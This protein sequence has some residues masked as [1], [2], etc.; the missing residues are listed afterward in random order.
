MTIIKRNGLGRPLTWTE[1]DSNF[2]SISEVDVK[3][4]QAQ[5]YAQSA[6]SSASSASGASSTAQNA[7]AQAV[8]AQ[9]EVINA[10]SDLTDEYADVSGSSKIG[11]KFKQLVS[12]KP[13]DVSDKLDS[14][15]ASVTDFNTFSS[16]LSSGESF[17]LLKKGTYSASSLVVPSGV[18]LMV[19]DGVIING[20]ITNNGSLIASEIYSPYIPYPT[21][22][23][24]T[25]GNGNKYKT[26]TP[27]FG[28]SPET[29]NGTFW[30]A[31]EIVVETALSIPSRFTDLISAKRFIRNARLFAKTTLQL[32]GGTYNYPTFIFDHV[33][34]LNLWVT[35]NENNPSSVTINF[36]T[37]NGFVC[38]SGY[39]GAVSGLT[40]TSTEWNSHGSWKSVTNGIYC[41]GGR[42][43]CRKVN[44]SKI[45]YG[46]NS[47]SGGFL[48]FL[49][50]NAN[51]CGD[52]GFFAFDGGN[53]DASNCSSTNNYDSGL[54]GVLGYGFVAEDGATMWLRN[55]VATGN[56]AGVRANIGSAIRQD[57]VSITTNT[58]GVLIEIGST[59]ETF[60]GNIS[61]NTSN[62]VT[63]DGGS[64]YSSI[65]TTHSSSST[66]NGIFLT[67]GSS[68]KSQGS[69]TNNN[70][71][72]GISANLGSFVKLNNSHVSTGNGV[73]GYTPA[74]GTSGNKNSWIDN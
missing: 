59:V 34:G 45:Y 56:L 71:Q 38:Y 37:S 41:E 58:V 10:V 47:T 67:T 29:D 52:G 22:F 33:D 74:F 54:V 44:A 11:Y 13:Q 43:Y 62:N 31:S 9:E 40:I 61:S 18:T 32:S 35:G 8:A 53:I 17:L 48:T 66:A 69:S 63:V 73:S 65:N 36:G 46:F 16:A 49:N 6:S 51:E 39:T 19:E 4:T 30:E 64:S 72:N 23:T 20:S 7:A 50:C 42:I 68:Y 70:N 2:E 15:I 1:L 55:P 28:V 26:V 25:M 24:V 27:V 57:N 14:S 21:G 3:L 5:G 12:A 60:G